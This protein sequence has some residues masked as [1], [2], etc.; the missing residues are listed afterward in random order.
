MIYNKLYKVQTMYLFCY[1]YM[2]TM[3]LEK[4]NGRV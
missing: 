3:E 2:N 4:P 1:E